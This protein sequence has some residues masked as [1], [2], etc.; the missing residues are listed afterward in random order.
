MALIPVS[1]RFVTKLVCDFCSNIQ[2]E[3]G[4]PTEHEGE[5]VTSICHCLLYM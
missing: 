1:T 2:D 5:E 3:V 4:I